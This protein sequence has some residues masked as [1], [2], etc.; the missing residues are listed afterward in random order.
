MLRSASPEPSSNGPFPPFVLWGAETVT[1]GEHAIF[2]S[3][4][5]SIFGATSAANYPLEIR[6]NQ[7]Q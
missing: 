1:Q 4:I 3:T 6:A 2:V 7:L 5:R